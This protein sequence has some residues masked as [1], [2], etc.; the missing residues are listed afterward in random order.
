M[1]TKKQKIT[2]INRAIT[3]RSSSQVTKSSKSKY[4]WEKVTEERKNI[5]TILFLFVFPPVGLILM[6]LWPSW[7][8]LIKIIISVV[9]VYLLLNSWTVALI[10]LYFLY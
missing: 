9:I 1:M 10:L 2:A 5:Y 6:W 7:P 3:E 4:F 8:L